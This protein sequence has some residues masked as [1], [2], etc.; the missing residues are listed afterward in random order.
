M[1]VE[2]VDEFGSEH[3]EEFRDLYD[4]YPWW[5]GRTPEDVQMISEKREEL[6][7]MVYRRS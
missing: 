2:V 4:Q 7:S 5:E 6:I 1:N 3:G